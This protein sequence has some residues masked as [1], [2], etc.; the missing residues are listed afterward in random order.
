MRPWF[1]RRVAKILSKK[2][3]ASD[4]DRQNRNVEAHASSF[5]NSDSISQRSFL[6]EGKK[7]FQNYLLTPSFFAEIAIDLDLRPPLFYRSLLKQLINDL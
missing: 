5:E 4:Y 2:L 6:Q 1:A 3:T 7:S